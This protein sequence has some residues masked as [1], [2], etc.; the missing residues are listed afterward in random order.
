MGRFRKGQ[1]IGGC[2]NPRCWVCHSAKLGRELTPKQ[3][4]FL[5]TLKEGL[6]ETRF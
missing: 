6:A 4:R 2:G 5:Q 1:R 3:L